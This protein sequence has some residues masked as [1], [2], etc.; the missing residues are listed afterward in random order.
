[1]GKW[2][3]SDVKN[4]KD[5]R[6]ENAKSDRIEDAEPYFRRGQIWLCSNSESDFEDKFLEEYSNYPHNSTVDILDTLGHALQ[7]LDNT[8]MNDKEFRAFMSA[9]QSRQ[10]QIKSNR[11]SITGY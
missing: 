5:N 6:S 1:M 2:Y 8:I 7:N 3:L 4:F 11:N 10:Q 9:Q